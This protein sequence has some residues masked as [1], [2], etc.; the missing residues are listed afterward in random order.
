MSSNKKSDQLSFELRT[1][2]EA[3]KIGATK[4]LEYFDNNAKLD[5]KTKSDNTPVTI[6]DPATE[7]VIKKFILSQFPD[8]NIIGEETGGSLK[9]STFWVIDPIDGTRSFIRGIPTWGVLISFCKNN[10][11]QIG[12][13]YFPLLDV[14]IW[15]E[16]GQGAFLNG[17]RIHVSGI[18]N[19]NE[20]YASTGNIKH[21]ENKQ[22]ILDLAD[23]SYVLRCPEATY[24]TYLVVCGKTDALIDM[25]ASLWDFSPF[26]TIA[27]EAGGKIT[28]T[29]GEPLKLTDKGYIV[30]NGVLHD[31][32]VRIVNKY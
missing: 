25:K 29:K 15:A 27:T 28:S 9:D 16:K 2:I 21:F 7:E 30:T 4:A 32:V 6:A 18:K 31:E 26:I 11:F 10:Q 3:A 13:C 5:Q 22:V 1:A 17:D 8:A 12:V 23:A 14:L 19:L 20:A 24:A